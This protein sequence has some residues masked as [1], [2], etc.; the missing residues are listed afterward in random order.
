MGMD[1]D[2]LVIEEEEEEEEEEEGKRRTYLVRA[3]N[4]IHGDV[5]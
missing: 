3:E 5:N 4:V 2:K 1:E